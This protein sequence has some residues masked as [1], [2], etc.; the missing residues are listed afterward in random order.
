VSLYY[1]HK[2]ARL[3]HKNRV[4][5]L[6][7]VKKTAQ[8]NK[9]R[10]RR[11]EYDLRLIKNEV[12]EQSNVLNAKRLESKKMALTLLKL[13][14]QIGKVSKAIKQRT[15]QNQDLGSDSKRT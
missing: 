3:F 4:K 12:G 9:R 8:R 14:E 7:K 5:S 11:D 6:K 1:E 13:R 2:D 10:D 15:E